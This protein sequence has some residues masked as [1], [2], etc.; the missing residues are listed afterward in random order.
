MNDRDIAI[1]GMSGYYP[2]AEN[3]EQYWH[4]LANGVDSITDVP[5]SRIDPQFFQKEEGAVDRFYCSRGGFCKPIVL[6]PTR[7][8]FLPIAAEGMDPEHLLVMRFAYEALEDAGIFEKNISLKNA[9]AILGKGNFASLSAL[10]NIDIINTSVQVV[11]ILKSAIPGITDAELDK[12]KKE[13]QKGKGRF[14]PDNAIAFMPNLV[15]SL[16]SNKL[17]MHGPAYTIDGAC[18][19]SIIAIQDCINLIHSGQCDIALAGG[20]HAGQTAMFWSSFN[21]LGAL[22]HKGE[23]SPFSETADG[24]LIG[25]GGGVLVLKT[26]KR[27]IEDEDRIYAV[28][29]STAIYS[30]GSGLS[31]MA[32]NTKGQQKAIEL[33]WKKT[34]MDPR[35]IGMVEAHGTATIVGDR[36]EINTLNEFF[37]KGSDLNTTWLGSVKS[38]IGHTMAAAGMAG[39]MKVILSLYHRQ[40]PPTLHTEK[41]A[42]AL[43]DS[44]FKLPQELV[45]WDE[46]KYPLIAGVNAFGFGGINSHAVLTAYEKK[47]Q[48]LATDTIRVKKHEKVIAMAAA[49][50]EALLKKIE[51]GD[52]T[53]S[54]GDYRL[55]IFNPTEERISRAKSL[56]EKDK[57]W[58]GRLDIWFSN[59]PLLKDGGK[60]AFLFPGFDPDLNA[61]IDSVAEYFEF[62]KPKDLSEHEHMNLILKLYQKNKILDAS[63]KKLGVKPDMNA[64]HSVGEWHASKAA[65]LLTDET[66]EGLFKL[67]LEPE[68]IPAEVSTDPDK[69]PFDPSKLEAYFVAVSCSYE[70]LKPLIQGIP[71]LY[72]SND[73]CNNQILMC[74]T[75]EAVNAMTKILAEKQIFNTEL[76][77][78]SGYHT[79]FLI[80][81]AEE[82]N[83]A[84][85]RVELHEP[86][87][88]VF[89]A[90]S[91]EPYPAD[92][93]KY[94]ELTIEHLTSHIRFR[95]LTEKL[96]EKE[97]AR[98][99]IQI[100]GGP[101][102]GFVEDT[103]KGKDF[104]TIA[105]SSSN[106]TSLEQFRRVLALLFIEGRTIDNNFIGIKEEKKRMG[107][108]EIELPTNV[109]ILTDL[110]SVQEAVKKHG[111]G[112][113]LDG[114]LFDETPDRPM[115]RMMNESMREMA[116]VQTEMIQAFHEMEELE[117]T[118]KVDPSQF[119][120]VEKTKPEAKVVSEPKV[121]AQP[122]QIAKP[123]GKKGST[124]NEELNIT[125]AEHPYVNDHCIIKQPKDWKEQ[126]DLNPVIPMT[127]SVELMAELAQKQDPS[128]KILKVGP[129]EVYQWMEVKGSFRKPVLG[130][131]KTEDSV[132]L[133]IEEYI[134]AEVQLGD[135][136]PAPPEEYTKEFDFGKKLIEP[137][138]LDDI[139]HDFMFHGPDYHSVVQIHEVAEGGMRATVKKAKGKGSLL[140]SMGQL[141]GVYV[142]STQ[143]YR[144]ITF[145]VK[146]TEV[147]FYQDMH[148]QEGTFEFL[149]IVKELNDNFIIGDMIL[150][151]DGKI[152]CIARNW[153]NRRFDMDQDIWNIVNKPYGNKMAKVLRDNVYYY[154]QAF[155]SA[156]SWGF[157]EKRYLNYR[158]KNDV[159]NMLPNKRREYLISRIAARDVVRDYLLANFDKKVFPV[160]VGIEHDDKGKPCL[161]GMDELKNLEISI[162]H[163]KNDSVAIISEKPVGIDIESIEDRSD[164]FMKLSFT[165]KEMKLL[166][167]KD[168]AEWATRFWVAK[169]A[170]S[171]M[172]GVG[173]KGNPK[174]YEIEKIDGENLYICGV[175]IETVK[176]KDK[177]IVG[178]TR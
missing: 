141:I 162:S 97:G 159:A 131:W 144:P 41:P 69:K 42:K 36:T 173:L 129:L 109:P 142:H 30:D 57:P 44:R 175:E 165:E 78:S 132:N 65:G 50:K 102:T 137:P 163:K 3:I 85:A 15:A 106:R 58:K 167:G 2:G 12:I 72:L 54:E 60:V 11:E 158:E 164:E 148:D 89:S 31:V 68:E 100:G 155:S 178:W 108:K 140:D 119:R 7:Y 177:F 92:M 143:T 95:E 39:I 16:I 24:L 152:W 91:L 1:V 51:T 154:E 110:S 139:Y 80:P 150:K 74:G 130:T 115:L 133:K 32:P 112:V 86:E 6:D 145:P 20:L 160:E 122:E 40:I 151:R 81:Y 153:L 45:E 138:T 61:E 125:L 107:S 64:G 87:I 174:Q 71:D 62:E 17:D 33:A 111:G 98:V 176:H 105:T 166:K 22:S 18:A 49:T 46:S 55:I 96:Y 21:M 116:S 161:T 66:I 147:D 117:K 82:L 35:R 70:T 76:P 73:N 26:L 25:E 156:S 90:T 13:F 59:A 53:I 34:D 77:F 121:Q 63:L 27:A 48:P 123:A 135:E 136:Y 84:L 114:A 5:P 23:I 93:E 120:K 37:G 10:R 88:P 104:G 127:M 9:C 157:L 169:E 101:L 83:K 79:P 126:E 128:K 19:S 47:V 103:L 28:I 43:L 172:L 52:H 29:K 94:R 134:N 38:N 75:R 99:F 56:V 124:F 8:G 118:I 171:K 67:W 14:Q 146:I 149:L 113:S 168:R 4:N 170:Y